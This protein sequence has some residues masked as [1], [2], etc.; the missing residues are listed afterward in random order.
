LSP[1][2]SNHSMKR[3]T[4]TM[5]SGKVSPTNDVPK[6]SSTPLNWFL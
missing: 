5:G 2:D 4:F 3:V 1:S 6:D